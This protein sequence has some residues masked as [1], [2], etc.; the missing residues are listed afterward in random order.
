M[1]DWISGWLD[2]LTSTNNNGD[3]NRF[4]VGGKNDKR[5]TKFKI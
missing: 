3:D 1:G 4:Y 5:L 2:P